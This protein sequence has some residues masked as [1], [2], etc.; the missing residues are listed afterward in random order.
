[1]QAGGGHQHPTGCTMRIL[2]R[3]LVLLIT[4][5]LFFSAL[6]QASHSLAAADSQKQAEELLISRL[7]VHH[8]QHGG[9]SSSNH[10]DIA[11]RR[12]MLSKPAAAEYLQKQHHSSGSHGVKVDLQRIDI[13]CEA[14]PTEVSGGG[15]HKDHQRLRCAVQRSSLRAQA[16]RKGGHAHG[17]PSAGSKTGGDNPT[18]GTTA[19]MQAFDIDE[20]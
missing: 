9:T 12:R 5:I 11:P 7:E 15:G 13:P 3:P 2:Q 6:P 8:S 14:E 4:A 18:G 16:L 10:G 17:G 19:G 20:S 1:M